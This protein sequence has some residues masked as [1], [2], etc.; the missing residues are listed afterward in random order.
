MTYEAP[1]APQ[2][3]G[4]VLDDWLR[5]FSASFSRCWVLA[6]IAVA[7]GALLVFAV[8]PTL[9]PISA[10]LWQHRFQLWS[11]LNGPQNALANLLLV[12]IT[13]T[14]TGAL[15]A[16]QV[17]LMR[18]Q[19]LGTGQ[20]LE[21]GL[22]RLLRLIAGSILLVLILL[23]IM[24]PAIIIGIIGVVLARTNPAE[25]ASHRGLI[26]IAIALFIAVSIAIIY[27][28]VRLLLW[29]AAVFT[30]D[31]G[32]AAALG[33]SWRLVKGHWWRVTVIMFV[34]NVVIAILG[35]VVP[36]AL[37]A[38]F[39]LF[40]LHATNLPQFGLHLRLA[41]L[42]SQTTHLLTL[43]LASAVVLVIFRDLTLRHEG[44]DLAA[45]TE[46]LTGR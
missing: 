16:T 37:S 40:S 28:S 15:F 36:W 35:F 13:L 27:V 33:R 17:R 43:P 30:E 8:T 21:I 26:P 45:R 41:Q 22:R 1:S 9:P 11:L 19:P 12:L 20:A 38:A 39:G 4:G 3:I 31:A 14:I 10:S 5:L 23:A 46:A 44:S 34:A 25:L 7:A 6:L 18:G 29:E 32:A 42:I 24:I 2:S